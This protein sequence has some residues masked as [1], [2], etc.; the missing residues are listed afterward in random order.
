MGE[1]DPAAGLIE[2][3]TQ[4]EWVA[5]GRE[6]SYIDYFLPMSSA[7]FLASV[8]PAWW[9]CVDLTSPSVSLRRPDCGQL[10]LFTGHEHA[11]DKVCE[12]CT[13]THAICAYVCVR[14]R[15]RVRVRACAF[16]CFKSPC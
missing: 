5:M 12:I 3:W 16:K 9:L 10:C 6:Q 4:M 2:S 11:L 7:I 1:L 13:H 15:L 8:S 14:V